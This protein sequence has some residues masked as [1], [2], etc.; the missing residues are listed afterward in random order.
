MRK[1]TRYQEQAREDLR[2]E[3]LYSIYRHVLTGGTVKVDRQ[4]GGAYRIFLKDKIG[5][6]NDWFY[7]GAL[8][9]C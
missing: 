1:K 3:Y 4:K 5:G 6:E 7:G 8:W 9:S 2:L